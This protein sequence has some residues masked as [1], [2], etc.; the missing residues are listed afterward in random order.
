MEI[1]DEE[2]T[3]EVMVGGTQ[4]GIV[5]PDDKESQTAEGTCTVHPHSCADT[6]PKHNR[7]LETATAFSDLR[8]R[9]RYKQIH[10]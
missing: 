7:K 8:N 9:P 1:G 6:R 10:Q 3:R 4:L 2:M 5:V